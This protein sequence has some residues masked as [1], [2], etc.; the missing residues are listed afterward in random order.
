LNEW[1]KERVVGMI[2][3]TD[4]LTGTIILANTDPAM[5]SVESFSKSLSQGWIPV[6]RNTP[7]RRL[8]LAAAVR[9]L[10][11][12]RAVTGQFPALRP[13]YLFRIRVS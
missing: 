12:R 5:S 7:P 11:R 1:L 8:F 2:L 6:L 13:K 4:H 3:R 9:R 10:R